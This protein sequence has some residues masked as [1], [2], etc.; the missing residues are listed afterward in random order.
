MHVH[1]L[2]YM[3]LIDSFLNLFEDLVAADGTVVANGFYIRPYGNPYSYFEGFL[4]A[5]SACVPL[6]MCV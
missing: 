1:V 2:A 5:V 3:L 4:S 6:V